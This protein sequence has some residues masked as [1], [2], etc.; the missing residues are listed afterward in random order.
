M[1]IDVFTLFPEAFGWFERQRH[2]V[3]AVALGT[4]LEYLNYRNHT[5]LS[6]GQVDDTLQVGSSPRAE[7]PGEMLA[8]HT[9]CLGDVPRL[10]GRTRAPEDLIPRRQ[11]EPIGEP[12]EPRCI[13]QRRSPR[14]LRSPGRD[15]LPRNGVV[16]T[17]Y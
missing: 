6:A 14:D 10:G 4:R 9:Q 1:E 16:H 15:P 7:F 11:L 17:F 13:R 3:N 2:V 8:R 5:P 12:Q